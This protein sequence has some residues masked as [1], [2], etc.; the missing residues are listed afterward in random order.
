MLDQT[1]NQKCLTPILILP[2]DA[3]LENLLRIPQLLFHQSHTQPVTIVRTD[4][5]QEIGNCEQNVC[6][7]LLIHVF[8]QSCYNF[9]FGARNIRLVKR[10]PH[11]IA[12][13]ECRP[14]RCASAATRCPKPPVRL[15]CK[16][17]LVRAARLRWL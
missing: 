6:T 11:S 10:D 2:H 15:F 16:A 12:S 3:A 7:S 14:F 5:L 17:V 1:Y 9:P 8:H 4:L 13:G